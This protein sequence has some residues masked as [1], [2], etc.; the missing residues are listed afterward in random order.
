[1]NKNAIEIRI[2]ISNGKQLLL[3]L[4]PGEYKRQFREFV[5]KHELSHQ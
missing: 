3:E 4:S 2:V 5:Q 1:M